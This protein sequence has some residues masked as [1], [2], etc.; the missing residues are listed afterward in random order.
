MKKRLLGIAVILFCLVLGNNNKAIAAVGADSITAVKQQLSL[1]SRVN[2]SNIQVN[3]KAGKIVF[4]GTVSS[5]AEIKLIGE[6]TDRVVGNHYSLSGLTVS[7]PFVPDAEIQK[8]IA[9]S[10]PS[11]CQTDIKD[12]QISVVGGVVKLS[13]STN[14]LHHKMMAGQVAENTRGVKA[15]TNA[16]LVSGHRASDKLIRENI[17]AVLNPY[18]IKNGIGSLN[19][20]VEDGRAT[21]KGDADSFDQEK[22]IKE[23][24]ENVPGVVAVKSELK[25]KII[26]RETY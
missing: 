11:H 7:P 8:A 5:L 1:D 16:I 23:T 18:L 4:S 12:L 25:R 15:V 24:A 3:L 10:I 21:L 2:A 14:A 13:G 6:L 26:I 19:V 20:T 17:L 9:V 22:Y